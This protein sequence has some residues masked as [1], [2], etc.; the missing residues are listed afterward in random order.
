MMAHQIDVRRELLSDSEATLR[1]VKGVLNDFTVSD[2]HDSELEAMVSEIEGRPAGLAELVKM[3]VTSYSEIMEV[4]ESL[5]QSRGLLEQASMDRIKSTGVK[6]QEVSSATETAATGMLDGLDRALD[7]VDQLDAAGAADGVEGDRPVEVRSELRDEL[8]QLIGLLQ[9]QD[10]TSQQLGY[11]S[12]VLTD[13]EEKMLRLSKVFGSSG[14][15]LPDLAADSAESPDLPVLEHPSG[16]T[17]DP[18]A[19]TLNADT[20]QALADEIFTVPARG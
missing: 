1:Q 8:H 20:R 2:E 16:Q 18:E 3:L 6:L 11:A 9:F 15:G 4:I 5:R 12:G 19:S 14:V 13:I 17:C 7:M 10:I